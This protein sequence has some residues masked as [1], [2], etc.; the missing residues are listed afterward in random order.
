MSSSKAPLPQR[1][2]YAA[3]YAALRLLGAAI[4]AM[5]LDMASSVIGWSWR[6][7]A[8]LTGR[9]AR[10][11][12]HIGAAYPSM[13]Q[14]E[15]ETLSRDMW[16]NLGR[17]MAETF[18]LDRMIDSP[19]R[20][21]YDLDGVADVLR[22]RTRGC[23]IVSLH[24]GNWEIV[25]QPAETFGLR[26]AGVYQA[27]SNPLSDAWL[28]KLRAGLFPG[29]LYAKGHDT[30]R[31]MLSHVRSG[32]AIAF[33]A[34]HR[35]VRGIQVPFFGRP[36][37]ANPFPVM[38]ARSCG[39]PVVAVRVIREGGVHFR[40]AGEIVEIPRDGDRREDIAAGTAMVHGVF[41]RW[42]REYPAQWMWIHRKW[43]N[44]A[45]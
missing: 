24:T 4:R 39:V 15:R 27:L 29:G 30:A 21:T 33:L 5:P 25:A 9:H 38:L 40:F 34:D 43:A 18:Q 32:G 31:R 13:P 19:G 8:P 14:A 44:G 17:I 20:Y 23:V 1:L 7:L 3:E 11:L 28:T 10:A 35:D 37:Y 16:E 26:T 42:I 36:A 2:R 6:T 12:E 22:D 41:E 45:A